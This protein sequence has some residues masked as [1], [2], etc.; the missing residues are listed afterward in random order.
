MKDEVESLDVRGVQALGNSTLALA[1]HFGNLNLKHAPEGKVVYFTFLGRLLFYPVTWVLP[2]TLFILIVF[3]G[4]FFLG[5]QRGRLTARHLGSGFLL[6]LPALLGSCGLVAVLWKALLSLHLVN[7]SFLS[8]Y[9]A[10]PY[11]VGLVA[12]T[13]AVATALPVSFRE[14]VDAVNLNLR[15]KSRRGWSAWPAYLVWASAVA[16]IVVL[17]RVISAVR[18]VSRI[19]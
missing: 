7:N 13:L 18:L 2:L 5:F 12:L 4:L 17:A 16:G 11:G 1:R 8:A 9:D 14:K 19:R 6:W 15:N 3:T 10:T